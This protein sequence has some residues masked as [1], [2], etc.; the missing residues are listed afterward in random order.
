MRTKTISDRDRLISDL[1]ISGKN[2]KEIVEET[3]ASYCVV[4][5]AL[6][7]VGVYDSSRRVH[8]TTPAQEW[9]AVQKSEALSKYSVELLQHGFIYIDGYEGRDRKCRIAHLTCGR[10]FERVPKWF[11]YQCP[12]CKEE[13]REEAKR[14]EES[15]RLKQEVLQEKE[16]LEREEKRIQDKERFLNESHIC[17]QCGKSF[18]YRTYCMLEGVPEENISKITYCSKSCNKKALRART[19]RGDHIKRAV[20]NGCNYEHGIT[21][22]KLI[23]RDGLRCALCGEL[24]DMSDRSY[25]NGS[26]PKYPSIDHI[27][28]ISKGGGHV[29]D[30]VQIA[31]IECNTRKRDKTEA[32]Y[33]K[34]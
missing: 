33:E 14:V 10:S 29:W 5:Y 17:P 32:D 6:K 34:S 25:G 18:C 1:Y 31:H 2:Q 8:N 23:K 19:D 30:N 21:L 15:R 20:K 3:G 28:P 11:T 9:N 27:I 12:L 26:G 24:C 16:R 13:A 22:S 4:R 7:K